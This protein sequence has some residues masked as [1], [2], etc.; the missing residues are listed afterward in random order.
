MTTVIPFDS[1]A[2]T[3]KANPRQSLQP[4]EVCLLGAGPGDPDLM[5]IKGMRALEAADVLVYDRLA[6]PE[7]LAFTAPNCEK[8]YVGKRKDRHSLPQEQICD[9]LVALARCDKKVVR[10]K[11]GDPFIFGRGGEEI[12]IL[13]ANN[14]P[15]QVIPG[16]TAATGCAASTGIPLTHRDCAHALTFIT[17]HRS[18]G[19][20]KFN[21]ELAL[22]KDQTVVFYMGLSVVAEIADGLIARG[23][24]AT[25]PIAVIANGTRQEQKVVV[26]TLADIG[27]AIANSDLP[28]PA[29]IVMGEVVALRGQLH[30]VVRQIGA[31]G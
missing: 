5:T 18:D 22:Q 13:E 3:K 25:T 11:G 12:D 8:I 9:L 17:A 20:L 19:E 31:A 27:E 1:K 16:I 30:A 26:S 15:W 6:N 14:I 7:L 23:K 29:L 21:W 28:S 2:R 24:A 4:G 10:L